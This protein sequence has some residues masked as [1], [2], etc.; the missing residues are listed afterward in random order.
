MIKDS[1]YLIEEFEED[2]DKLFIP[3]INDNEKEIF[4]IY[5]ELTRH[6]IELNKLFHIY[7]C[8]FNMLHSHFEMYTNDLIKEK[9]TNTNE[10]STYIQINTLTIN[11]ISSAKTL[12]ESIETFFKVNQYSEK[13]KNFKKSIL[14]QVYDTVFPYRF[15]LQLRNYSQHGHLPLCIEKNRVYFDPY[16]IV[17]TPHYKMTGL[18]KKEILILQEDIYKIYRTHTRISFTI[19]IAEFNTKV[20]E[21]YFKFIRDSLP[22]VI[23]YDEK[24]K[25]IIKRHPELI[26]KSGKF[27]NMVIYDY[28]DQ[29]FHMFSTKSNDVDMIKEFKSEAKDILDIEKSA[30]FKINS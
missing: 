10:E 20:T 4:N 19:T 24:V 14:S 18:V 9:K 12:V 1:Y 25:K 17:V 11:L 28:I 2:C 29:M 21:I 15:L 26:I 27:K 22:I 23:T 13:A 7:R 6:I 30:Y 16:E 3:K 5:I 8:N